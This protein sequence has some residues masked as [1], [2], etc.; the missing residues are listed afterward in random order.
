LFSVLAH[1][2]LLVAVGWHAAAPKVSTSGGNGKPVML[3]L[4]ADREP[5]AAPVTAK[6][7]PRPDARRRA[8][9]AVVK[10]AAPA[11]ADAPVPAA[12]DAAASEPVRGIA[13]AAPALDI[14]FGS[15]S[16][17]AARS[18]SGSEPPPVPHGPPPEVLAQAA[19]QAGLAHIARELQQ[20][21]VALQAPVEATHGECAPADDP[22][23][24]LA[25]DSSAL[26]DAVREQAPALASLLRAYRGLD[27]RLN[28]VA[29]S[30]TEEGY[31][32][33]AR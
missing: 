17:G 18:S 3:W 32:L 24:P 6:E 9:R 33:E 1:G 15:A 30:Y 28:R 14:G 19:R 2:V 21:L 26:Q 12:P 29:L 4:R 23:S 22:S 25:C 27:P 8:A 31:R 13:F 11:V 16:R 5:A 10:A 20:R 7:L